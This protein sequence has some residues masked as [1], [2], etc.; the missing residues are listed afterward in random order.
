[1]EG[2][3]GGEASQKAEVQ[4]IGK[5]EMCTPRCSLSKPDID[6]CMHEYVRSLFIKNIM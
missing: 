3:G 4:P 2:G 1:M 5:L 6:K